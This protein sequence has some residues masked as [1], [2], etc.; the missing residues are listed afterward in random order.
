M[1]TRGVPSRIYTA[2]EICKVVHLQAC[3]RRF[4]AQ[5]LI[6]H[7]IEHP[8]HYLQ[9]EFSSSVYKGGANYYSQVVAQR[10]TELGEF[11]W[12]DAY[13]EKLIKGEN[14]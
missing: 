4:L 14:G 13:S 5:R 12:N 1:G 6:K 8:S 9:A 10:L 2:D 3:A 11:R 7:V